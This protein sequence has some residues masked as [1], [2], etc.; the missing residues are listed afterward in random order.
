MKK[1][2][3]GKG[4]DAIFAE[5]T[6]ENGSTVELRI[7]EIEP[8]RSQ[9]RKEFDEE[10][11]SEL[12]DSIAQHGL[13]QPILVRPIRNDGYQIVAGE[14]R[15][16]ASR[17][18]GLSTVP[19]IIKEMSDSETAQIALVENLQ[20]EDLNALEEAEGYASLIEIYGFTQDEV[21]KTVGKSRPAVT[22][23]LRLLNLPEKIREYLSEGKISAGHARALLSFENED[24]MLSAATLVIEKN[25]S[26]RELE[27]LAKKGKKPHNSERKKAKFYLEAELALKEKLGRKIE[28]SG[29]AKKGA[30]RIEFYGEDDLKELLKSLK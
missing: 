10:A 15:W 23:A 26:V 12:A 16:R 28:I 13:I 3:L 11:L 27:S 18:A 30:V 25:L 6:T 29:S 7:S 9:P 22:N 8:N 17:M 20:R 19:V 5:N 14:R 24:E 1:R 4:L 2:G 21:S